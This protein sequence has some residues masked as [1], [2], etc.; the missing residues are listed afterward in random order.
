M[1]LNI[2]LR[3]HQLSLMNADSSLTSSNKRRHDQFAQDYAEQIGL[4]RAA[5]GAPTSSRGSVT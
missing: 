1:D 4:R 5:M 2:L 3:R